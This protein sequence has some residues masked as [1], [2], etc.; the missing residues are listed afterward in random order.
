M[1]V[2]LCKG[3]R[4]SHGPYVLLACTSSGNK[5]SRVG[6]DC[7]GGRPL[8]AD[9]SRWQACMPAAYLES[10]KED[11]PRQVAISC[12]SCECRCIL[13]NFQGAGSAFGRRLGA[14]PAVHHAAPAHG[15]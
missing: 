4:A 11:L 14:V 1:G 12:S 6:D 7:R 8:T 2:M 13:Q 10:I 15:H 3:C 9:S 5:L